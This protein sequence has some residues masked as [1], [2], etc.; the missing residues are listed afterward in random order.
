MPDTY[1]VT[2][3]PN[4]SIRLHSE[5]HVWFT[6]RTPDEYV[7]L[8]AIYRIPRGAALQFQSAD[9]QYVVYSE[10]VQP[11]RLRNLVRPWGAHQPMHL[12]CLDDRRNAHASVCFEF[13]A[14]PTLASLHL[15]FR[16]YLTSPLEMAA[17]RQRSEREEMLGDDRVPLDARVARVDVI[18]YDEEHRAEVPIAVSRDQYCRSLA[19][20]RFHVPAN[21]TYSLR[22]VDRDDCPLAVPLFLTSAV[23]TKAAQLHEK[24]VDGGK[25]RGVDADAEHRRTKH[26]AAGGADRMGHLV[27]V[28]RDEHEEQCG[29]EE[30]ERIHHGKRQLVPEHHA[31]GGAEVERG[32]KR[33]CVDG[34]TGG[35]AA[36]HQSIG[37][38]VE[39]W[40]GQQKEQESG[41]Q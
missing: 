39:L 20:P 19:Q 26:I 2:I 24:M 15:I 40:Q 14:I 17:S 9:T 31:H 29:A 21:M 1:V 37:E 6:S 12:V 33:T 25:H 35:R 30:G 3:P 13:R 22:A 27:Q 5:D 16:R 18:F 10:C 41:E 38:F 36:R 32:V 34:G 28:G 23:S 4:Q 7:T 11:Y 8:S